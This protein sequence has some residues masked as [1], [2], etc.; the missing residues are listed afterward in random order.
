MLLLLT[1]LSASQAEAPDLTITITDPT[2]T[3]HTLQGAVPLEGEE[4]MDLGKAAHRFAVQ[5]TQTASGIRV[6]G[7]LYE[8][9]GKKEKV[10][11]V[12][13]LS[14][15]GEGSSRSERISWG[16]PKGATVPDGLNPDLLA[17]RLAAEWEKPEPP[18]PEPVEDVPTEPVQESQEENA[19]ESS[20]T[21]GQ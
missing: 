2:G 14:L 6:V 20:D 19:A 15:P 9:K 3:E 5:A 4:L 10:V 1:L 11:R 17:W 18:A 8:R 16:A 13:T 12:A 7:E 21:T